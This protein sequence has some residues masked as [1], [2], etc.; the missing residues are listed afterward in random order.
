MYE[1]V[2]TLARWRTMLCISKL[3]A[4]NIKTIY[5]CHFCPFIWHDCTE[6]N[7][8]AITSTVCHA[9]QRTEQMLYIQNPYSV[10]R[11][12]CN[13]NTTHVNTVGTA[14]LFLMNLQLLIHICSEIQEPAG[15]THMNK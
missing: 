11:L 3:S 1:M 6:N 15:S 12:D 10:F 14:V 4:V 7:F 8:G 2:L 13:C 5:T 9:L